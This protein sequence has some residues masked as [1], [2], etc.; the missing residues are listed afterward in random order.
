MFISES[1]CTRLQQGGHAVDGEHVKRRLSHQPFVMVLNSIV[2]AGPDQFGSPA[3]EA[4][5][6]KIFHHRKSMRD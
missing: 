5:L 6:D 4:A 2:E 3:N 1:V